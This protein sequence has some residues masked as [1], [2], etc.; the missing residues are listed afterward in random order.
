MRKNFTTA[1]DHEGGLVL[2]SIKLAEPLVKPEIKEAV[3]PVEQHVS[4]HTKKTIIT[5]LTDKLKK[6][7]DEL[8]KRN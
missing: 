6:I 7:R 8:F 2:K 1:E 4:E 3:I 5:K